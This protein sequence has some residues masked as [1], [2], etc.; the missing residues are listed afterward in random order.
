M[1]QA[2]RPAESKD[3]YSRTDASGEG[4]F[5]LVSFDLCNPTSNLCPPQ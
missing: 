1:S 2:N 5:V 3:P 4:V